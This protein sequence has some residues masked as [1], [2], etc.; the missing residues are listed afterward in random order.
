[1]DKK[2]PGQDT[3]DLF[4]SIMHRALESMDAQGEFN[5]SLMR[6]IKDRLRDLGYTDRR[7]KDKNVANMAHRLRLHDEGAPPNYDHLPPLGDDEDVA[8]GT[9]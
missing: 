8:T 4:D 1:M 3:A 5:A 9:G 2:T 7:D 6:V